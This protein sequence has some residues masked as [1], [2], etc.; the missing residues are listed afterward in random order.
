MAPRLDWDRQAQEN[1][2]R[3]LDET[4]VLVFEPDRAFWKSW[5]DNRVAMQEAGYYVKKLNGK[6]V[7][8]MV[9]L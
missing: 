2:K 3:R 7:V 4:E 8:I 5:R 9:K 1:K 6:W